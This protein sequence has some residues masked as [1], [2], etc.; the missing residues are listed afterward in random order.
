MS[1]TT[2][3]ICSAV[4]FSSKD[5]LRTGQARQVF[6]QQSRTD[7]AQAIDAV[8]KSAVLLIQL[9]DV[10]AVGSKAIYARDCRERKDQE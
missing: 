6:R 7:G 8:A 1:F 9:C 4:S 3:R 5:R 10:A 2:A